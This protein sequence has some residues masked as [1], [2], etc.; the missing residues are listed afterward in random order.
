[1]GRTVGELRATLQTDELAAWLA[2]A[3]RSPLLEDRLDLLFARLCLTVCQA[4]GVKTKSGG[5]PALED[6]LMFRRKEAPQ[7]GSAL[8]FLRAR[9]N[10]K[11]LQRKEA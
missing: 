7:K 2:F 9:V 3:E 8:A 11:R 4:N 10:P 1:M 5:Q 6:F